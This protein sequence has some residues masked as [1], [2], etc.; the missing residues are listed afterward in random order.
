MSDAPGR[1]PIVLRNVPIPEPHLALLAV[2]LVLQAARPLRLPVPTRPATWGAGVGVG[3]SAAAIAWA[4][5]AAGEVDL[6]EPDRLVTT[7]PYG[8]TR[9]PMYEAWTSLYASIALGLRNGWLAALLPV[10]LARVH[11][12]TGREDARLRQRFGRAHAAYSRA[13]PRYLTIRLA[14]MVRGS[15]RHSTRRLG[16]RR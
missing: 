5:R 14:K 16:R 7:G 4:T 8:L 10:L 12:D 15:A 6:A 3:I 9:H 13:V 2:G 1:L 11:R